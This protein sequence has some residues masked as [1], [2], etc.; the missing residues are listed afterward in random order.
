MCIYI[1]GLHRINQYPQSVLITLPGVFAYPSSKMQKYPQY[2]DCKLNK[3]FTNHYGFYTELVT[4]S[5][6][7]Y[8]QH[9]TFVQCVTCR[10][11]QSGYRRKRC[12]CM[13]PSDLT[14]NQTYT[15][16]PLS[17]NIHQ[18]NPCVRVLC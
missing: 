18:F 3:F 6:L 16:N 17:T 15:H 12:L 1:F 11:S 14:R 7:P 5:C 4:L 8:D 10:G 13:K 2:K 9:H